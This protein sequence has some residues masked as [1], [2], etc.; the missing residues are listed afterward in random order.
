MRDER[1]VAGVE[2]VTSADLWINGGYFILR[3]EIFDYIRPGEELVMEPFARLAAEGDG[4]L[5]VGNG[6]IVT[7]RSALEGLLT[8]P[9][10]A[11]GK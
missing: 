4:P 5:V 8:D 9:R 1:R 7:H 3:H 6:D 2:D 10:L 11:T